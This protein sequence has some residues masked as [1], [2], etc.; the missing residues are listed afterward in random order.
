MEV[1]IAPIGS[2]DSEMLATIKELD[3]C[4]PIE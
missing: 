1:I 4:Q 2:K 3:F